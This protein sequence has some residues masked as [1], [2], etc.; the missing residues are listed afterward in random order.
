MKEHQFMPIQ[1]I[2]ISNI[3]CI[4][5]M[6]NC[7]TVLNAVVPHWLSICFGHVTNV[8]LSIALPQHF[9]QNFL[10]ESQ[11][12]SDPHSLHGLSSLAPAW[13]CMLLDS[14][15]EKQNW[16]WPCHSSASQCFK[17]CSLCFLILRKNQL[18]QNHGLVF[19]QRLTSPLQRTHGK[20]QAR[21]VLGQPT[22]FSP[23]KAFQH[24]ALWILET[25]GKAWTWT[26]GRDPESI[27][28]TTL[29]VNKFEKATK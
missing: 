10:S 2:Y 18:F 14:R 3:L 28:P 5:L 21:N 26:L 20:W 12:A 7:I 25:F 16:P 9:Q 22:V 15:F 17:L 11:M 29:N 4:Y 1:G 24:I 6:Y 8:Y 27:E 13:K 23:L 19:E